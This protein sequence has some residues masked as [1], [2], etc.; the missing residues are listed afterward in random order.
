MLELTVVL[1]VIGLLMAVAAPAF[2]RMRDAAAVHA[3]AGEAVA[4]FAFAR[5]TAIHRRRLA[6]IVFDTIGGGVVVRVGSDAVFRRDLGTV[7]G[8]DLGSNRDSA[9]YDPKGIAYGLSNLTL[10]IKRGGLA[11][12]L[13]LSRLGRVR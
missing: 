1:T 4:G 5:A 10:I 11:D 3:A 7:Y 2:T 13:T 6:A 12:T 9:V 8:I